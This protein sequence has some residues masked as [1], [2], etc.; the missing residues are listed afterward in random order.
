MKKQSVKKIFRKFESIWE[1]DLCD[2]H[3]KHHRK[4]VQNNKGRIR[5]FLKGETKLN[6]QEYEKDENGNS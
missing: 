2:K 3:K 5:Q 6:V 4:I 1:G